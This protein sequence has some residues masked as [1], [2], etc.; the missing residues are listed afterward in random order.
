[1]P[2][3]KKLQP[4]AHVLPTPVKT[5]L[6][7][8]MATGMPPKRNKQATPACSQRESQNTEGAEAC[9]TCPICTQP[10]V[11]SSDTEDGEEALLCE[12]TCNCWLH[13]WCGGVT[14]SRYEALSSTEQPFYCPSCTACR[15][16]Q[17]IL[18]LQSMV[19]ALADEVRGLKATVAGL[20]L[21][22]SIATTH[23]T[24][25][26]DKSEN[27][28]LAV[29]SELQ[30]N[31]VAARKRGGKGKGPASAK[32]AAPKGSKN[33]SLGKQPGSQKPPRVRV[34]GARKVWGTLKNTTVKGVSNAL[35]V[36][37]KVP[38]N[39]LTIK[40]KYKTVN[41]DSKRVVRWWFVIRGEEKVLEQLENNWSSV[42]IQTAW[43]LEPLLEFQAESMSVPTQM[44]ESSGSVA[45]P[46]ETPCNEDVSSVLPTPTTNTPKPP[47]SL[48]PES[49]PL[50]PVPPRSK[51]GANL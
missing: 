40:R 29:E 37:G 49:P 2:L 17:V 18:E 35:T 4:P 45:I 25:G 44:P 22:N 42:G 20:Q 50:F 6:E 14:K 28:P 27:G 41:T 51:E 31:V 3:K 11:E 38:S 1:M 26:P 32:T 33:G 21:S 47:L 46:A 36:L 43:K 24:A 23:P 9:H 48:S 15:Q 16:E 39:A 8:K 10:I 5:S 7:P 12:G 19:T 30:W 34:N 13:R